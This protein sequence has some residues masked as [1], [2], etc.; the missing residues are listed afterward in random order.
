VI[1]IATRQT[2]KWSFAA[3]KIP[4][5]NSSVISITWQYAELF[6]WTT[7]VMVSVTLNWV[8]RKRLWRCEFEW[9]GVRRVAVGGLYSSDEGS[10]TIVRLSIITDK[11][12]ATYSV[13][14]QKCTCW[15]GTL[16]AVG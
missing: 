1:V 5:F 11:S 6:F 16:H 15:S 8:S 4:L 13:Q 9:T 10:G 2:K 7:K 12:T 14:A 3:S